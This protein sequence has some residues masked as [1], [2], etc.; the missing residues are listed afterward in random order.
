MKNRLEIIMCVGLLIT[1]C[2]QEQS[3]QK[4]AP[5]QAAS[6]VSIAPPQATLAVSGRAAIVANNYTDNTWKN[7]INISGGG[8][9]MFYFLI[10]SVDAN[11]I[12]VGDRLGFNKT[13][14]AAVLKMEILQQGTVFSVFVTVDKPLDPVGDGFPNA[15]QVR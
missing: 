2:G 4:N 12:K 15:I 7:G 5:L 11:P 9:N 10:N 6:A 14:D 3:A 8:Q 1:A 13:G